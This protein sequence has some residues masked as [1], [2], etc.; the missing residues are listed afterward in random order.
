MVTREVK[1][2]VISIRMNGQDR[3]TLIYFNLNEEARNFKMNEWPGQWKQWVMY[4]L[5]NKMNAA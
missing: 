3:Q 1:H 4:L 5:Q 2:L